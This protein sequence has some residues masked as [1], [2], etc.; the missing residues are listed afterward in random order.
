MPPLEAV[1]PVDEEPGPILGAATFTRTKDR[2]MTTNPRLI[3][4]AEEFAKNRAGLDY[5]DAL[6]AQEGRDL[7]V[8]ERASYDEVTARNDVIA[9]E[10]PEALGRAARYDA[11][12]EAT[13]HLV[14]ATPAPVA[15]GRAGAFTESREIVKYDP[16]KAGKPYKRDA[17]VIE[18]VGRMALEVGRA[19]LGRVTGR[20]DAEGLS[21][22]YD[23]WGI[24]HS[25]QAGRI[26]VGGPD[27][28]GRDETGEGELGRVV[29]HGVSGDGTAP[30]TIEGDL[31][32]F[33]DANRYA[34]NRARQLP[35]P[36][37]HA[38]TFKRPRVTQR[39]TVAGQ[40]TEGDIL[41]SQRLQ[42]TGDTVT[43]LTRGGVLA[44]S[45]QEIDWTDPALLGL[46][47][48]DLAESY[49]IDTDTVLTAA[50][51]AAVTEGTETILS[52][53]AA[54]DVF[55]QALA[56]GAAQVYSTSK[57]LADVLFVAIDR[58]AY[59]AGLVDG[60]GRPM[61]PITGPMNAAGGD[62]GGLRTF[63]GFNVMG[64]DVVVD[65]NFSANVAIIA[66]SQLCEFYEQNKGLLSIAVPST[67][68]V[69]YAYRGY[70]AANVYSQGLNG[71]E[72]A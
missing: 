46:A 58:W 36:D 60:D 25:V 56:T 9:G 68:E 65:P 42:L 2:A 47:I 3:A 55:I 18:D 5:L 11:T 35:M 69:Q 50:I 7:T 22:V 41:S 26:V 6:A 48:Q 30:I 53:T 51:E 52:L 59:M 19:R 66:V 28:L 10:L 4:L 15:H 21:E 13:K 37:N 14:G 67:L 23:R 31:I 17:A 49:A 38:P 57:K 71:L 54:S 33:V 45:E 62:T 72:A 16:T 40:T 12:A 43:K 20:V 1:E 44:L 24:D 8:E 27:E 61:F 39:T 32:K 29:A 64:L 70:V 63:S 34:V